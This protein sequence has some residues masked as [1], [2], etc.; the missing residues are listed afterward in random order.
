MLQ[1]YELYLSFYYKAAVM[2]DF[3]CLSVKE[4]RETNGILRVFN[5]QSKLLLLLTSCFEVLNML[6]FGLLLFVILRPFAQFY[7]KYIRVLKLLG[8]NHTEHIFL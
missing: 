4:A 5:C 8:A 3:V 6:C 1:I 2:F 7:L